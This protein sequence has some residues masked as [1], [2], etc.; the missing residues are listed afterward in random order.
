MFPDREKVA[1]LRGIL[2]AVKFAIVRQSGEPVTDDVRLATECR[3]LLPQIEEILK[4]TA[5]QANEVPES[6][7]PSIWRPGWVVSMWGRIKIESGQRWGYFIADEGGTIDIH[8]SIENVL[9]LTVV[10]TSPEG[11]VVLRPASRELAERLFPERETVFKGKTVKARTCP[12]MWVGDVGNRK[13]PAAP[14]EG[15]LVVHE[16]WNVWQTMHLH[17]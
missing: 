12:F 11:E 1:Q 7:D 16:A 13:H 10:S 9:P 17:G 15:D 3:E 6:F 4:D 8:P 2:Y 5:D 14:Q